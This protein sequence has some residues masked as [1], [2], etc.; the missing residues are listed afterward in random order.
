MKNILQKFG[1]LVLFTIVLLSGCTGKFE[2]INKSPNSP[3]PSQ[4]DPK[5]VL[6]F[7]ISRSMMPT[8]TYQNNQLLISDKYAQYYANDLGFAAYN[9]YNQVD[10]GISSMWSGITYTY[11]NHLNTVIRNFEDQPEHTNVVQIARIWKSW[12]MLRATDIW[13]DIPYF[14][15][16]I[17]TG[18]N[19][20]YDRQQDIYDDL[21]KTLAD[22]ANKFDATKNNPLTLDMLY[23]GDYDGWRKFAN[24]LRLRMAM[25]IS[26]ADPARAKTEAEA[27]IAAG[28]I[29][30]AEIR[31]SIRTDNN[32]TSSQSPYYS[33]FSG[34]GYGMSLTMENILTG[35]GGQPWPDDVFATTRPDVVDPRGP[36]MYDPVNLSAAGNPDWVGTWRGSR[37]GLISGT[38]AMTAT[39]ARMGR[40]VYSN[41]TRR[42]NVFKY[43]E[44][45]FL[46]AEAKARFPSWSTGSGTAESWY[47]EGIRD[48]MA[49]WGI[50][51]AVVDAYL[52]SNSP[53]VNGTT[54]AFSDVSGNNNTVLDKIMTQ[55]WLAMFPDCSWDSW[56]DHRR[57]NKPKLIPYEGVDSQW[58]PG[59]YDNTND[60]PQSFI[61]RIAYPVNEQT[62]NKENLDAA[63]SIIG[64]GGGNYVGYIRKPVWW[65][66]YDEN[67][68]VRY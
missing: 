36:L 64:F 34:G 26:L 47:T 52:L 18:D 43:S 30:N 59:N 54:V 4:V 21:F 51:S 19:P 50:S 7:V 45:C 31:A 39:V 24:S 8:S 3:E 28:L 44:I 42:F 61:R 40:Y 65:D 68:N 62:L 67:G 9:S 57:T 32:S 25:R 49:E 20:P 10:Q 1:F 37:P 15:A 5:F 17:G 33:Y 6:S 14:Q 48:N 29:N 2:E 41:P 13:G 63:L 46:L 56:A 23:S 53:N 22:A 38:Q 55:K 66:P 60:G 58:F 35:L 12:L 27:A 16:C 11:L